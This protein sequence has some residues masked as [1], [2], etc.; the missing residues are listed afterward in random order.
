M[1]SSAKA[2]E[3]SQM[4]AFMEPEYDLVASYSQ[5]SQYLNCEQQYD[6][7]YKQGW[8]PAYGS[9]PMTLGTTGHHLLDLWW[10]GEDIETICDEDAVTEYVIKLNETETVEGCISIA[11]HAIWLVRRYDRM[12][13]KDRERCIVLDIERDTIFEL[14][15]LGKR[16][17]ALRTKIDKLLVSEE[18]GGIVFMDHK[19]VGQFPKEDW[20]DVDPQFSIYSAALRSQGVEVVCSL[21]DTIYTYQRRKKQ[22]TLEWDS[23]PVEESF[24]RVMADRTNE[25][26]DNVLADAYRA[27]D[28]MWHLRQGDFEPL[29]S[30]TASCMWCF[31]RA[32]CHEALRGYP[33]SEQALLREHFDPNI[34]RPPVVASSATANEEVWI[35]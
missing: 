6:Y 13:E 21:L 11:D 29:R 3:M 35:P 1:L 8:K 28:R 9:R 17:Y 24:S 2:G 20:I 31:F 15:Q 22:E 19:F 33:E 18:H 30:I 26:L 16:R 32:P 14:P 5:I 27:C 10:G 12:Y 34:S 7:N 4:G 25:H 23:Y